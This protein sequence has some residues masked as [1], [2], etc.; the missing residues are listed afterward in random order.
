MA[1]FKI[2]L[3]PPDLDASAQDF[4][5]K[6]IASGWITSLGPDLAAFEKEICDFT[7]S[8]YSLAL[9]SGTAAIHLGLRVLGVGPGD[10]VFC[11]TLTFAGTINPVIY[12]GGTPF[13]VEVE[14]ET[15]N[16]CPKSLERAI[17]EAKRLNLRPK[18]IMPV[19]LY[20][21]PA[22]MKAIQLIGAKYNLPILEDA[23]EAIGG[24]WKNMPLGSIGEMGIFSFNGNKIITTSGG[25]IL[26]AKKAEQIA[27]AKKLSTVAREPV[28]HYQHN[29]YG[30]NYRLS[31]ILA[32]LG[33]S[34]LQTLPAKVLK[35][36]QIFAWYKTRLEKL[37]GIKFQPEP[38]GCFSNRWLSSFTISPEAGVK[39]IQIIQ[40]LANEK[41]EARPVWKPLHLQPAYQHL[42]FESDTNLAEDIFNAGVC[43]P[44]GSA[45]TETDVN[46]VCEVVEEVFNGK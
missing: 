4:V 32:A 5:Q 12:L 37:E 44:S 11:P 38:E 20:G 10:A 9:N 41:I 34:E 31:N 42:P 29:E 6:A 39:P 13:L 25:G 28:I 15:W 27:Y 3:S 35:R 22:N 46:W 16:M 14:S 8:A 19:H 45:M 18:V 30:Y 21:M 7:N 2:W 17:L 23:A 33:R 26:L 43:L 1:D 40:A 24:T 36:R